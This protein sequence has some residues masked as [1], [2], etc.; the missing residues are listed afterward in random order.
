MSESIV[1]PKMSRLPK[2]PYRWDDARSSS[3]AV[4]AEQAKPVLARDIKGAYLV[5]GYATEPSSRRPDPWR[6]G[7][8]LI[9]TNKPD[10]G[11]QIKVF[12]PGECVIWEGDPSTPIAVYRA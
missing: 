12:F 11:T 6:V 1:L 2:R 7:R 5:I 9:R 10:S 3:L 8:V 4:C